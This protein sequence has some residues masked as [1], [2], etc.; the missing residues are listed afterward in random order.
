MTDLYYWFSIRYT[1]N[2]VKMYEI[3]SNK[4]LWWNQIWQKNLVEKM[5]G[6][7]WILINNLTP[8]KFNGRQI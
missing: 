3:N 4:L 7:A 6:I 1:L 8:L 2:Y 5:M